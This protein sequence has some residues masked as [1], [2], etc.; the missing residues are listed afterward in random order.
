[1]LSC[2]RMHQTRSTL[3]SIFG[4]HRIAINATPHVH[5]WVSHTTQLQH[6]HEYLQIYGAWEGG[7]GKGLVL[8]SVKFS[9]P[10][11]QSILGLAHV[12]IVRGGGIKHQAGSCGRS[13]P[14]RSSRDQSHQGRR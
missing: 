8:P 13:H 9:Q 1:M 6:S 5:C 7:Q 4:E 11:C 3:E 14:R 12:R 10:T 2:L